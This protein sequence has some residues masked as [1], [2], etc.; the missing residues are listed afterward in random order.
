MYK[1][2]MEEKTLNE[3][4]SLALISQMIEQSKRNIEVGR[5]NVLLYWGYF[6]FALSVAINA[7][8]TI[9]QNGYWSFG[10]FLMFVFWGF[11]SY[12]RRN[13]KP[14]IITYTDKAI[15]QV[16]TVLGFMFILST[17]V[18]TVFSYIFSFHVFNLMM[19]L[20]LL[21]C[22][23]GISIMGIILEEPWLTYTPLLSFIA[24]FY[25]LSMLVAGRPL[26]NWWNLLFGFSFALMYIIPGHILNH[27]V[28]KSC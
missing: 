13:S 1:N 28:R 4:E 24:T 18:L 12:K 26:C 7:I 11:M 21:Y 16:W 9:T 19:P 2:I 5:G 23:L 3:K 6:T 20:S 27:K 15:R 17:I 14:K 8:V 25:M 10:W 22:G